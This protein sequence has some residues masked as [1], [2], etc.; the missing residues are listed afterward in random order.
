MSVQVV[1]E[2][3][4]TA[5]EISPAYS[6]VLIESED[7]AAVLVEASSQTVAVFPQASSF[8]ALVET[9]QAAATQV[10]VEAAAGSVQLEVLAPQVETIEIPV[11]G[12]QGAPGPAGGTYEQAFTSPSDTW[13]SVHSLGFKP[14][15]GLYGPDGKGM[16]GH[17]ESN[18]ETMTVVSFYY[19]VTGRMVLS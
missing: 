2:E 18:T 13:T 10:L 3:A 1:I 8:T 9:M 12:I 4:R 5:V 6:G 14:N 7:H 17:V 11:L 19:P 15:V 16:G